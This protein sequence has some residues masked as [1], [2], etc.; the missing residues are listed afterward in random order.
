VALAAFIAWILLARPFFLRPA[1]VRAAELKF[2]RDRV[3]DTPQRWT[4]VAPCL[5]SLGW[6]A[7]VQADVLQKMTDEINAMTRFIQGR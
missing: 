7:R 5:D 1:G 2:C 4:G 6:S 3:W